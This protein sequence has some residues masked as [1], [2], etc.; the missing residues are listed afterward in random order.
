MTWRRFIVLFRNLSP[1]GATAMRAD[2]LRNKLDD[3][4]DEDRDKSAA[5]EFFGNVLSTRKGRE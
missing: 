3:E 1:Y 5:A 4:P 2:E